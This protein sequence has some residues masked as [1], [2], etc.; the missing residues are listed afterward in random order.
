MTVAQE[1]FGTTYNLPEN[2]ERQWGSTVRSA[3]INCMKALD[4]A[5]LL[6]V[7]DNISVIFER[8]NSTVTAGVT[9]TKVTTWHRLTAASAVTLGAVTAIANGTTDGELLILS[10]TSDT[11]TVTVPDAA[12]TDLN[13]TWVGGLSDFLVLMWNSTTTNWE[14][15]FRNR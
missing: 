3:L 15:I 10:G 5:V 11:N 7:N 13:G 4:A 9:L 12:N 8:T 1:M 6:D 14:E 2:K